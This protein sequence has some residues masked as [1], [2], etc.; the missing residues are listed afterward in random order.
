MNYYCGGSGPKGGGGPNIP[1]AGGKPA[2][3]S[4]CGYYGIIDGAY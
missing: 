1:G 3:R 4:Y 2:L